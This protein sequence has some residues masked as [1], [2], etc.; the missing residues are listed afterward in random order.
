MSFLPSQKITTVG[1][2]ITAAEVVVGLRG[3]NGKNTVFTID[4]SGTIVGH[5]KYSGEVYLELKKI[6]AQSHP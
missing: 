5:S 6:V 1:G 3:P 2:E 4:E